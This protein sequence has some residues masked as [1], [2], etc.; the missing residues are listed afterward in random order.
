MT[1]DP[2][3]GPAM[4]GRHL[5]FHIRRCNLKGCDDPVRVECTN[6]TLGVFL[7]PFCTRHFYQFLTD[8]TEASGAQSPLIPIMGFNEAESFHNRPQFDS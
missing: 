4:K 8:I 5:D 2:C 7:M 1:L 6:K 3:I